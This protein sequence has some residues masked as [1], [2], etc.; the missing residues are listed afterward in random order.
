LQAAGHDTVGLTAR[1]SKLMTST[2]RDL[3]LNDVS[4]DQNGRAPFY[5]NRQG[6]QHGDNALFVNNV[7]FAAGKNKG[8]IAKELLRG[9][10]YDHVFFFDDEPKNVTNF[11]THVN[12]VPTTLFNLYGYREIANNSLENAVK[13]E[14]YDETMAEKVADVIKKLRDED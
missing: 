7:Y 8:I 1:S 6:Y 12:F 13:L 10:S 2:L 3:A 14:N 9:K 5:Y 4:F 11:Q